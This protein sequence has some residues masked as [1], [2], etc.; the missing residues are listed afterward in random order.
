[1]LSV[2]VL[3]L[4]IIIRPL[5]HGINVTVALLCKILGAFHPEGYE[6][7]QQTGMVEWTT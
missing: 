2:L 5:V 6:L 4:D 1:M 7:E 3:Q